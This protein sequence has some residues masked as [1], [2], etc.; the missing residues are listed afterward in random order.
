MYSVSTFFRL[1]Q[2]KRSYTVSVWTR[3]IKRFALFDLLKSLYSLS[4]YIF[5]IWKCIAYNFLCRDGI[6]FDKILVSEYKLF[7]RSNKANLFIEY[8]NALTT[9]LPILFL[10]LNTVTMTAGTFEPLWER[11]VWR[12]KIWSED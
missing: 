8:G 10:Y 6:Y 2:Y 3:A 12:L 7:K 1:I 9:I 11:E 4:L 5:T